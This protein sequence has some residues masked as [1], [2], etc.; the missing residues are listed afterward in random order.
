LTDE[1]VLTHQVPLAF[2]QGPGLAK[3]VVRN[4]NLAEVVKLRR[5]RDQVEILG[6][7]SGAAPKRDREPL[8]ALEVLALLRLSLAERLH[9]HVARLALGRTGAAPLLAIEPLIGEPK[10]SLRSVGLVRKRYP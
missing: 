8:N 5:P 6:I 3:D 9:E 7:E 10:R 1:R 2:C 4:R